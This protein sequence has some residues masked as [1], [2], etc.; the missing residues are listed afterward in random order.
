MLPQGSEDWEN[1]R[2]ERRQVHQRMVGLAA[3]ITR[4]EDEAALF[5]AQFWR[6]FFGSMLTHTVRS[7][8]TKLLVLVAGILLVPRA[9]A[10]TN[11]HLNLVV[12]LDLTQSIAVKGPDGTTEFQKNVDGV[13]HVLAQVPT[14][15]HV[16]VIGITDHSFAQPYILLSAAVPDD[17]GYFGERL[18]AAR[19]ELVRV[20]KLRCAHLQPN[21]RSTDILG[22]LM[23]ASQIFNQPPSNGEQR[24]L[25][26]FSDM[27]NHTRDLDLESPSTISAHRNTAK[28]LNI[29]PVD[30]RLVQMYALGVDGAGQTTAYWQNIES[31]WR[32]YFHEAGARLNDFLV[33]RELPAAALP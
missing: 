27:R 26:L 6:D 11:P 19:S 18:S 17:P 31:F 30:L 23:L 2:E 29:A 14:G 4:L 25:V 3:E 5:V 22:A 1:L 24:T 13:T 21:F 9:H 10:A 20:W 28:V 12:A 32:E 33:L 16:T 7:A 15:T 8:M